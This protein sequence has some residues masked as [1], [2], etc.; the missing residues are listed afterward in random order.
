MSRK[1]V[2]T[3]MGA[4]SAAGRGADT[5]WDALVAGEPCYRPIELF[6]PSPYPCQL[7]GAVPDGLFD[8]HDPRGRARPFLEAAAREALERAGMDGGELAGPD[9]AVLLGTTLGGMDLL[10][11]FMKGAADREAPRALVYHDAA[12][13][14]CDTYCAGD[15]STVSGAC[16]SSLMAIGLAARKIE[17]GSC[18]AVLAGGF[19]PFCE[20]VHA[21][22][23]SLRALDPD[24]LHPFDANR[25]GL[26]LG[27][28]AAV[29]V[30]E[31]AS[32]A[33]AAGRK[34]LARIA[35]FATASDANHITGPHP[36]G[37]GLLQAMENATRS[38]GFSA[39]DVDMV[40]AHGTGTIY[41][42]RM[43]AIAVRRFLGDRVGNVPV[44][45]SKGVTG[46]TVGA[47]GALEAVACV[48]ALL[49]GQIPPTVGFET[50]D[51]ECGLSPV[52]ETMTRDL[53]VILKT[54]A[55]FGGQ[56]AAL[57][58]CKRG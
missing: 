4:V 58:L 20:F 32:A 14:L 1:A 21:G 43:E 7:A 38:C 52:M 27:E 8:P 29:L 57:V 5:L 34:P 18:R 45:G 26:V 28:G 46:H 55:G 51:D 2:I 48:Q 53:S 12:E 3:G 35:G 44:T 49:R 16:A 56:N 41:N 47:A 10:G 37:D 54:A 19:D 13:A 50:M 15:A 22:F 24:G 9:T 11:P 17:E 33:L 30:V 39:A 40:H 36:H 6:D 42:D 23:S 25:K 31:E